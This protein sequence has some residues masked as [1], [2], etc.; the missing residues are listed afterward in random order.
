MTDFEKVKGYLTE[1]EYSIVSENPEEE[2]FIVEKGD[3]G[4]NNLIIDCED[5]ILVIEQLIME[6]KTDDKNVY[7][8]LLI[9]NRE[10][11]HGGFSLSEDGK[12]LIYRDTL[13]LENLDLN[14]LLGTLNAL[15]LMLSEYGNKLIEISKLN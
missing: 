13:E 14:E 7:K 8:D 9:M 10:I 15:E 5:N 1:L 2:L 11:I 6:L 4:I 12:K 3:A